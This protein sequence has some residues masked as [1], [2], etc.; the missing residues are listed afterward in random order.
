MTK[1][2]E[3]IRDLIDPRRKGFRHTLIFK[4]LIGLLL[5]LLL[6]LIYRTFIKPSDKRDMT[7]DEREAEAAREA[8]LDTVD[9]V[10]DY[11]WPGVKQKTVKGNKS[12]GKEEPVEH[13]QAAPQA[14]A[15]TDEDI[16]EATNQGN[17]ASDEQEIEPQKEKNN[18]MP[19]VE[20][21][22][23]PTVEKIE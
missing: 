13:A 16:E 23:R 18:E 14:D 17:E 22:G 10:G 19:K 7:D 1:V 9:I 15:A 4:L 5:L 12:D 11:L 21:M 3:R 20:T 8:E 2:T 6:G